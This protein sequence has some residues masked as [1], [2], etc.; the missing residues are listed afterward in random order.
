MKSINPYTGHINLKT[1][2]GDG[3]L[4]QDFDPESVFAA[5]HIPQV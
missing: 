1:A 2:V 4:M 3:E 5:G